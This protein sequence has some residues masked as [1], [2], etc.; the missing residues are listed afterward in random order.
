VI[1]F[2]FASFFF[3]EKAV[4]CGKINNS[5]GDLSAQPGKTYESI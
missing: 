3:V 5:S 2:F 4:K 1:I